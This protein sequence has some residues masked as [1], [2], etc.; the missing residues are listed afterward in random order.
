M[1]ESIIQRSFAG[2]ELAPA[3]H[4]RADQAKYQQGLRTCRNFLIRRE[5]GASNRPGTRFVGKAK[6][7]DA[8][9]R[10][11]RYVGSTL[12]DS[13]LVEMGQG[14]FRFYKA[15]ARVEVA[16]VPAYNNATAYVAGDLVASGGVVYYAKGATTG[17]AP[18]D[19]SF[20]HALEMNG[21]NAIYEIPTPYAVGALPDWNQSGNVVTLTHPTQAPRELVHE[22]ATRWILRDISTAPTIAVP[23]NLA[24]TAGA[25]GSR[26]FR[27][28]VTAVAGTTFEESNPSGVEAVGSAADPTP[29]APIVLTWDP[30]A[31]AVEYNVY[32]DPY[33]NGTFG[34]LGSASGAET[35]NDVGQ[36]PDFGSAPPMAR[37]LFTSSGTYPA[38]S[39]N[40]KQR[41]F[42]A[43]TV[44]EPDA[45][46][47][48]RIGFPSNFG[49]SSPVQ[50]DD[51]IT[52]RL[53]GNN[54]HPVRALVA[55]KAGLVVLTDGGE[56]T[57]T[58]GGGPRSPLTPSSIDA[59]QE[60]YVGIAEGVPP[61]VVGNAVLYVQAR[62]AILRDLQ[63]DQE[64][65]GLAGRDLT[66]FGAHLFEQRRTIRRIDYQQTPHSIIWCVRNDGTLLGLTYV[67][68]QEIWGW[69]RHDT[70]GSFEDVCVVPESDQDALYVLVRRTRGTNT[71]R[72]IERMEPREARDG[73][74]HADSFFVDS[75][76]SYSSSTPADEF[77]GLDH[78]AG[79]AVVALADGIV[80]RGLTVSGAGTVTLPAEHRNVHIGLPIEADLETLAI[81]VEGSSVRDKK[82][83]VPSVTLLLDRSARSFQAGPTPAMLKRFTPQA[84]ETNTL[85]ETGAAELTL[86]ATYNDSGRVL[87]R[88][89]DPLP[90]T[91][92]GIIPHVVLG[93]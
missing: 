86:T 26:T 20:W 67:P 11:A 39:A 22:S 93:G 17:N 55:L 59:L 6:S 64:V 41:R 13:Y 44:Q 78:L 73:F 68:D 29:D 35:F 75:G 5:G 47:G 28:V 38:H 54:H 81:D 60:T 30:V 69:H 70:D 18:P 83:R 77:A 16:G 36:V 48:S 91:V 74:S 14:Y 43:R 23:A 66:I 45:I 40:Y 27:Y 21:A 76:L 85:L 4:A 79:K 19:L 56:W 9:T 46:W 33:G 89:A 37:V 58:G 50:D 1:G 92:L 3:L 31:G 34:Y 62:G 65:E 82:K 90:L 87:V 10:L 8:G 42:F 25:A 32:G 15:G 88:Q 71:H 57:V 51:A 53:A 2:G 61:V 7:D 84:W 24:G 49:I 52:F 80:Y 63:F 72:Y 12:G